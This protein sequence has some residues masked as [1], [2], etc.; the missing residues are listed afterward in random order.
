MY[1]PEEYEEDPFTPSYADTQRTGK[2]QNLDIIIEGRGT[3]SQKLDNLNRLGRNDRVVGR[4]KLE[5]RIHF[6]KNLSDEL[7][8]TIVSIPKVEFKNMVAVI[9][10]LLFYQKY[11]N[12]VDTNDVNQ[13]M[14]VSHYNQYNIKSVITIEDMYRYIRFLRQI[15]ALE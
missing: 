8:D 12:A 15:R 6:G 14:L 4:A 10:A 5:G 3:Y 9:A 1:Y 13:K 2:S 7:V 11:K